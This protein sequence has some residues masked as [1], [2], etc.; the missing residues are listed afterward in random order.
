MGR[1]R[2]DDEEERKRSKKK[3]KALEK[4]VSTH[5]VSWLRAVSDR[6]RGMG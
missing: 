6:L 2:E 5:S 4:A 1:K 3:K